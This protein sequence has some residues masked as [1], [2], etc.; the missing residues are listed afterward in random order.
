MP[1][2][3]PVL[4][5]VA[6]RLVGVVR[7]ASDLVSRLG[8]DEFVLAAYGCDKRDAA[9]TELAGTILSRLAEPI[10][11]PDGTSVQVGAS[12]G[13]ASY[14]EDGTHRSELMYAADQAMYAAK[15]RGRHRYVLAA[16][17]EVP[18]AGGA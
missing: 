5:E 2:G 18:P 6:R 12:I 4:I 11:L 8:G 1:R 10:R 9:V 7:R 14:P 15:R 13:I 16:R 17:A 3:T